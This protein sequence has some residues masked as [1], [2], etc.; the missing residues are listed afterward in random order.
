MSSDQCPTLVCHEAAYVVFAVTSAG[1]TKLTSSRP[2]AVS[3][4]KVS[5]APSVWYLIYAFVV[6]VEWWK[7]GPATGLWPDF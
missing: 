2:G 5:D 1:G 7:D 3:P 6:V 4:A